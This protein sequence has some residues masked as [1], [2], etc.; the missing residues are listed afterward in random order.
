[1]NVAESNP[2]TEEVKMYSRANQLSSLNKV[3]AQAVSTVNSL[4]KKNINNHFYIGCGSC[5]L[6]YSCGSLC[7]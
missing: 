7:I 1:M 6:S 2:K 3:N 5:S 4:V